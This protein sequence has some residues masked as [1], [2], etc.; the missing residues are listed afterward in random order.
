MPIMDSV[1]SLFWNAANSAETK[2]LHGEQTGKLTFDLDKFN[3]WKQ[4]QDGKRKQIMANKN[5]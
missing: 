3:K 4:I 1:K 5:L 2:I